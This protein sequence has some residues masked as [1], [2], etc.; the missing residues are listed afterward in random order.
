MVYYLK[1]DYQAICKR[2]VQQQLNNANINFNLLNANEVDINQSLLVDEFNKLNSNLSSIG[3]ELVSSQKC[4]LVQQLMQVIIDIVNLDDKIVTSKTSIYIA[5][6]MG[7]SYRYLSIIF[8]EVTLTTIENYMILQ[9]IEKAKDMISL[10]ELTFTEI[11]WQLNYS[12]IGHFSMQFKNIT[13]FSPT[14]FKKLLMQKRQSLINT[15][16]DNLQYELQT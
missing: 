1:Y 14:L 11:A 3:I 16:A 5:K 8:T 9:K 10:G 6:K 4:V 7:Y 2:L 13:G 12:S 15:T